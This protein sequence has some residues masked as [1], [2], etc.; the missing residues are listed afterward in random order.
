MAVVELVVPSK[1]TFC[2]SISDHEI[3]GEVFETVGALA[4]LSIPIC[5][6]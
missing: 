4:A 2:G 6:P 1:P 3:T 5:F